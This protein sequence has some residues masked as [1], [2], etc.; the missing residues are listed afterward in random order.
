MSKTKKPKVKRSLF[1]K[2]INVF[3]GIFLG[4]VFLSLVVLGFSQ[5]KTFREILREK[6][7]AIAN[8]ELNGRLNIEKINGTL[9]TSLFLQNTSI[10]VDKDTL[11][12]ARKIEIKTSPLQILLKKIYVRKILLEDVKLSLLEDSSGAWN[13]SKLIKPKPEDTTKS[14]FSFIVQAADVQLKNIQFRRQTFKNYNSKQVYKNLNFDDLRIND[15]NFSAQAYA[16]IPQ[17]DFSIIVK[18]LSFKPNLSR[19]TL[20][21]ISGDFTVTKQFASITNFKFITDSSNVRINARLDSLNILGNVKLEDFKNYPLSID[22]T[23]KPFNFD[24]LSSFINS[25]EILKGNPSFELKAKGKFGGFKIDKIALDYRNTHID[26][27][28]RVLNL[29]EPRKLFIQAKVSNTSA[30]YKD[31]NA[32]LPSLKL[33]E[34]AKLKVTDLNME[35][36]GEPTNF[37]SKLMGN[38]DNGKVN[39]D[40]AM[41]VGSKPMTYDIKFETENLNLEPVLNFNT[42]LNSKGSITGKGVSPADLAADIKFNVLNSVINQIPVD[43]FDLSSSAKNR[44]INLEMGGSSNSAHAVVS[45]SVTFDKDTI[46]SYSL[47]GSVRNIDIAKFA[48]DKNYDSNLNFSFSAQGKNF[49]PDEINGTFTIGLDSSRFKDKEIGYSSIEGTFKK[50]STHREIL[51][52]SDFV[53][54]GI[55]GSFSLKKAVELLSYESKTIPVIV[56]DKIKELNP[57]TIINHETKVDTVASDLP[58]IVNQDLKF[59]YD[60]KFKDFQ[61]IAMLMGNDQLDISGTGSGTV[62]NLSGNF[63]ISTQLNLDYLVMMEKNRTIYLSDFETDL[64]FTRDNRYLSFDKIFGTVSI[65]GKRFY[66]KSNIKSISADVT[67]NQSKLFFNASANY[68]DMASAEIEG[69]I[70][71]T[72]REQQMLIDKASLQYA[73]TE[74][75][76][77]DTLKMFFNPDQFRIENWALHRDKSQISLNGIIESSGKQNLT[78]DATNISGDLL[79]RYLLGLSDGM[80]YAEGEVKTKIGGEFHNPKINLDLSV[81]NLKYAKTKLGNITGKLDYADKKIISSFMFLDTTSNMNKPL[82]TMT[83]TIPI[84]LDFGTIKNR[85]IEN[86][87]LMLQLKSDD[88]NLSSL[89]NLLPQIFDQSGVLRADLTVTGKINSPIYGGYLSLTQCKFKSI[90][91]NLEYHAGLKLHVDNK[92]ISVDSLIVANPDNSKYPGAITGN[93]NILLDGFKIKDLNFR[94]NGNLAVLGRQSQNVSPNLY[95]DLLIGTDGDWTLTKRGNR[96]YFSGNILL[97]Q[98]DL[99]YVTSEAYTG[100]SNKNFNFVYVEDS[101]KIDKELIRFKKILSRESD[102]QTSGADRTV[103]S[104]NFDYDI[105]IVAENPARLTFILSQAANQRLIV[106]MRGDLKYSNV[107]GDSYAQGAFELMSGSKLEFFKTFDATGTIRFE[108]DI[109]NPYLDIIATYTGDYL[110]PRDESAGTQEVAVKIKI[111]GPLSELGKSLANNPESIGVY[112]GTRNIQNNV[113]E[114]RYDYADAFSFILMGKFKD[115]LTAQDRAQVAGQTSAI[116]NTATSFLGSVLTSFVNSAVGDLVNNISISQTG[117]YTKFFLSGRV[118]NLRYT[119]GGTTE[120]FQNI[121]KANIKFEYLFNPRFLIRLERRDPIVTS[122]GVEEKISEIAFKYKFEF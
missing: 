3:I 64:N 26:M 106:E 107:D 5:T 61:L 119:F 7:I 120:I 112:V 93:G 8:K 28:G 87:D 122:F 14:S 38:I 103:P 55:S 52:S 53:D 95:G 85:F 98:T 25:T 2:I 78:I 54:F 92:G 12:S 16:D 111:K 49:D 79:E 121:G 108:T 20:K 118:Q 110:D 100:S 34:F 46:P 105:G 30:D 45:G 33:P 89:G 86:E 4:I 99:T 24:D 32:L 88:F 72:P 47:T 77:K 35:Y 11:L 63:S 10:I 101:T 40:A 83:G 67:F 44:T 37:K 113:R 39:I 58:D 97:Q 19:F 66:S 84:D 9:L 59:N 41:N 71:M 36:E 60:F 62:S 82:I 117:D 48:N 109:T 21:N 42:S 23:A 104:L 68:E 1:R 31:V 90:Y 114:T 27:S 13:L 15:L 91:N 76:N 43:K 81:K 18:D 51:L 69:I 29:N 75:T 115:D 22:L 65:T 70:K 6:V 94:F 96:L 56:G 116:G 74:W 17:S 50:D 73:G 57:L 80:L 102:L